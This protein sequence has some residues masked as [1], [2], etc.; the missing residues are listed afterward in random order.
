[1][2]NWRIPL[3]TILFFL[4][5]YGVFIDFLSGFGAP[6]LFVL[7]FLTGLALSALYTRARDILQ[8]SIVSISMAAVITH[9]ISYMPS[10]E[11]YYRVH[12]RDFWPG[13]L[14]VVLVCSGFGILVGTLTRILFNRV[15]RRIKS[16]KNEIG[17]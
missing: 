1:M 9:L 3:L 5:F 14:L 17:A 4:A 15:R 11:G 8:G 10:S 6:I 2:K 12:Q 13:L 7:L 16:S